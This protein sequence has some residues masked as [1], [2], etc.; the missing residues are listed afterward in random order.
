M[1][2]GQAEKTGVKFFMKKGGK[3]SLLIYAPLYRKWGL[4]KLKKQV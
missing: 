4:D 3:N 2:S 1:G